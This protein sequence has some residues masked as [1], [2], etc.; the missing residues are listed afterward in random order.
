[1]I[2]TGSTSGSLTV[3]YEEYLASYETAVKLL[4][5]FTTWTRFTRYTELLINFIDEINF[6]H[7]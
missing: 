3:H 7:R 5:N 4:C 1:M 2:N 6:R